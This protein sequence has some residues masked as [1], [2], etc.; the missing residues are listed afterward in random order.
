M[1]PGCAAAAAREVRVAATTEFREPPDSL[2]TRSAEIEYREA[3]RALRPAGNV[4][5]IR[6]GRARRRDAELYRGAGDEFAHRELC[7]RARRSISR[8]ALEVREYRWRGRDCPH[9]R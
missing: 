6:S 2:S 9:R 4:R 1:D 8:G 5:G 3:G 7:A